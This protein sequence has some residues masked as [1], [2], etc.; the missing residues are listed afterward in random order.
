MVCI[1][2]TIIRWGWLS[3][4]LFN[5]FSNNVSLR[6]KQFSCSPP[7][8]CPLSFNCRGL[9]S[10]ETYRVFNVGVCRG[11]CSER[12]DFPIPGSPPIKIIEPG[13]RPPPKIRSSSAFPSDILCSLEKVISDRGCGLGLEVGR[14]LTDLAPVALE[15]LLTISSTS[16]FHFPQEGHCPNHFDV[17]FPQEVQNHAFLTFAI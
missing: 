3:L 15:S 9:S 8:L 17:S 7:N 4:A 16:V 13:T 12:V 1:E 11:I 14:K 2:S 5:M 10:P 6:I